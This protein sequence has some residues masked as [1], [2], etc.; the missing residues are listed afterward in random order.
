MRQLGCAERS[1]PS[2]ASGAAGRHALQRPPVERVRKETEPLPRQWRPT[3]SNGGGEVDSSVRA[4]CSGT[5]RMVNVASARATAGVA[6]I[7]TAASRSAF[8]GTTLFQG[9]SVPLRAQERNA[10]PDRI[11]TKLRTACLRALLL[12]GAILALAP[13]AF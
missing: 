5:S 13:S 12:V 10:Y 9:A 4:P 11:L 2:S 3:M 7:A 8:M 6:S 1:G